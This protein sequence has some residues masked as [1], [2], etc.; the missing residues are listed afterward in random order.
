MHVVIRRG[1]VVWPDRPGVRPDRSGQLPGLSGNP[2]LNDLAEPDSEPGKPFGSIRKLIRTKSV[3]HFV[4]RSARFILD[5][6]FSNS[7][8]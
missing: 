7:E 8:R 1:G 5:K 6:A 4:F 3:W 2:A